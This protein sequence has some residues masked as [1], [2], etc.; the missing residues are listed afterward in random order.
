MNI[1]KIQELIQLMAENDLSE[2]EIETEGTKVRLIKK[3][4][5]GV[6]HQVIQTMPLAQHVPIVDAGP[7]SASVEEESNMIEVKS[8]MVGTFYRSASPEDSPYVQ[9]G[10]VVHKGDVLCIV[11]AMKLMNEVKSEFDGKITTIPVGNAEAIEYGQII[12]MIEPV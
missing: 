12:F 2:I 3:S 5:G 6:E 4:A 10:D 11:E 8:P 7:V 9:V 1:K